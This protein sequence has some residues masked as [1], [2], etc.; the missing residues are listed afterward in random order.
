MIHF[1]GYAQRAK[2]LHQTDLKRWQ[3]AIHLAKNVKCSLNNLNN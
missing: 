2:L 3:V 1:A